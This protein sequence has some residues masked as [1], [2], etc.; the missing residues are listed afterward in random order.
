MANF[1][2]R[3]SNWRLEWSS[4]EPHLSGDPDKVIEVQRLLF[5]SDGFMV[6]PTGPF[7]V[8]D[9]R[10]PE[11][12]VLAIRQ[13]YPNADFSGEPNLTNLYDLDVPTDGDVV[14]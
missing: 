12:V 5:E 3:G 10:K 6:T 4:D 2:A 9:I 11:A 8:A 7:V 1:T 14:F 13:L